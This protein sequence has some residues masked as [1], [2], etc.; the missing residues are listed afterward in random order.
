MR[1]RHDVCRAD[2]IRRRRLHGECANALRLCQIGS[3]L[4]GCCVQRLRKHV[5]RVVVAGEGLAHA[6]HERERVA[7]GIKE[8]VVQPAP[9]RSAVD[10]SKVRKRT[11]VLTAEAHP[12]AAP[13]PF[14][15]CTPG[16]VRL[17]VR[18]A[19]NR[20]DHLPLSVPRQRAR[21]CLGRGLPRHHVRRSPC[22]CHLAGR[23]RGCRSMSAQSDVQ[24]GEC[25]VSKF[26][27]AQQGLIVAG[28]PRGAPTAA[29][30]APQRRAN[31]EAVL[32]PGGSRRVSMP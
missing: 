32:M 29:A 25:G 3:P 22:G 21:R 24:G 26:D 11:G 27:H 13:D 8:E 12:S 16:K 14:D 28:C 31:H 15:A 23:V 19:A 7:G 20:D 5:L 1:L 17:G 9:G 6:V 30:A 2:R 18:S 10:T 4:P